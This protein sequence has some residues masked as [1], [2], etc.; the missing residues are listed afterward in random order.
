MGAH[1]TSNNKKE[2]TK[3]NKMKGNKIAGNYLDL[4][5]T[6]ILKLIFDNLKRNKGLKIV[7]YNKK[8]QQSLDLSI[9][10]YID[11]S[12]NL[13]VEVMIIPKK[14]EYGEFINIPKEQEPYFHIYFN[15]TKE[16]TKNNN[17]TQKD[18]VTKIKILI[19]Y[20]IKSFIELFK[21][22]K[23]IESIHF[24]KFKRNNII[25][26]SYMFCRCLSLKEINFSEFNTDNVTNMSCMFFECPLLKKLNLVK[27]NTNNVTDMSS[28]FQGCSALKEL[29]ISNFNFSNIYYVKSIF[30]ECS[31]ELQKKIRAQFSSLKEEAFY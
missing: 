25:D 21:D 15:G 3:K 5:G 14:N 16:E 1:N 18:N 29:N 26:M 7:K 10:D 8:I 9:N 2:G 30:A 4:K 19:D 20:Q 23:C 24:K 6:H 11:Y 27:F 22:C 12:N 17:F 13:S 31:S 28:M